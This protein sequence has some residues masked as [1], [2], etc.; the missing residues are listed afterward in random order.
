MFK[1]GRGSEGTSDTYPV[2]VNETRKFYRE[3]PDILA[4]K[5]RSSADLQVAKDQRELAPRLW[6]TVGDEI[7]F[8]CKIDGRQSSGAVCEC[9]PAIARYVWP[10][11]RAYQGTGRQGNRLG[12]GF[13]LSERHRRGGG[14][15]TSG[16][17]SLDYI[18]EEFETQA[19]TSPG[20][21]DFLGKDIDSGFRVAQYAAADRFAVSAELA[22]LL[23]ETTKLRVFQHNLVFPWTGAAERV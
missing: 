7:I 20:D 9:L 2:W 13:S 10:D 21:F 5:F 16:I 18:D 3:F 8:C 4:S 1:A 6:K 22:L 19:D 15:R 17:A 11:P 23:C 12:S 14:K